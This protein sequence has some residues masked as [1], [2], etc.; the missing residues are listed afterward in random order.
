MISNEEKSL[1]DYQLPAEN[2]YS[3]DDE[4]AAEISDGQYRV[5]IS[6]YAQ[7]ELGDVVFVELPEPGDSVEA[8]RPF[9]VIESVKAVSD[10]IA[11]LSGEIISVNTALVDK[12][13]TVNESCY[14]EG[15][16]VMLAAPDRAE[17]DAL[18]EADAYLA[19]IRTRQE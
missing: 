11:P 19:H 13:E 18:M 14:E 4:W 2:R 7:Q 8:G 17:F 15:W 6:D 1:A 5:G 9:G 16:L 10:L 3:T 12:P